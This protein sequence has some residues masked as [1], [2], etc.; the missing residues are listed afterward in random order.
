MNV[1]V[2]TSRID[3]VTVYRQGA[4]VTRSAILLAAQ[5]VPPQVKLLGLPLSLDDGSVRVRVEG[6]GGELPV[7]MDLRVA[8]DLAVPDPSLPPPDDAELKQARRDV[9]ALAD[10]RA[11]LEAQRARIER[12]QVYERPAN[13]RGQPPRPSPTAARL[14]LVAFQQ[15]QI[16]AIDAQLQRLRE[17]QRQAEERREHLEA[18]RKAA[19]K[20]RQAKPHELRKAALIS[21]RARDVPPAPVRLIIEYMVPGAR[22]APAY[23][24]S[25]TRDMARATVAVRAMV[26]QDTGEDWAGVRLTLATA[27]AQRWV[28]LP[29]MQALR[30][31]RRQPAPQRRGWRAPPAGAGELYADYDRFLAAGSVPRSKPTPEPVPSEAWADPETEAS[32]EVLADMPREHTQDGSISPQYQQRSRQLEQARNQPAPGAGRPSPKVS[33]PPMVMRSGAPPPS[34]ASPQPVMASAPLPRKGGLGGALA[35]AVGGFFGGAEGGGPQGGLARPGPEPEHEAA[36]E[37]LAYGDLRMPGPE[38]GRRGVL[39]LTHR[40]E[41]YLEMLW[42]REVTRELD[43]VSLIDGAVTRAQQAGGRGLP[44]RHRFAESW[45]GFDYVYAAETPV[46]IPSDGDYH[47]VPLLTQAAPIQ[48]GYVVVPRESTDVYRFVKLKNPL[49]APLLPG[50]ADIYVG[51]DYLLS[52]DLKVAPPR[53]EVQIGLGVEQA[54]KVSRNTHF[55]EEAAGLMGGSLSLR[56]DLEFEV[57]NRSPRPV[58]VEVQE[59]LPSVREREDEIQ[60]EVGA[61]EPAWAPFEP[62]DYALKGGYRWRVQVPAG[63]QKKLT[64]TYVVRISAKKELVGGNRRE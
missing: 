8:L 61:V 58:E 46:D 52:A 9:R 41:R 35:D 31:G 11:H 45:F 62:E 4:L 39:T 38:A 3:S 53:G 50:P 43:V 5:P 15:Q 34:P 13:K 10:R 54:I 23:A 33:A 44:P 63:Q 42:V 60:V 19:S 56:H 29:E 17:E 27:D 16:A 18:R 1:P 37:Q 40:R 28:E 7:A 20:A 21:L 47:S 57:A 48:L 36:P 30:I 6:E 22:W 2:L 55:R 14:S 64:A 32:I 49:D 12:L 25:L 26:A 59:R 51:G 24:V